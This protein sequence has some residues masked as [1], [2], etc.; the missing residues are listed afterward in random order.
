MYDIADVLTIWNVCKAYWNITLIG[1][2]ISSTHKG[3]VCN[4]QHYHKQDAAY[5]ASFLWVSTALFSMGPGFTVHC[6]AAQEVTSF[7]QRVQ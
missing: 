2:N 1:S 6:T 7:F 5:S 4:V 3:C